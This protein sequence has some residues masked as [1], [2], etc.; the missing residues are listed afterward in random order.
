[1]I[2]AFALPEEVESGV[3]GEPDGV[4]AV[5]LT[6]LAPNGNGKADVEPN[7]ITMRLGKRPR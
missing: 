6:L 7:K 3:L 4:E 1:M 2:A 5:H